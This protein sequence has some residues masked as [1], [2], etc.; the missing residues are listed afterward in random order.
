MRC[1]EVKPL[2][3]TDA[4]LQVYLRDKT[5]EHI[6]RERRPMILIFPGG[7]YAFTADREAE[8]IAL[9]FLALGYQACVLR[10]SV[11]PSDE[12]PALGD[13]PLREAAAALR[14]I[15]ENAEDWG[16]YSDRITVCGFSAGG[17]LA[18]SIG[19]LWHDEHRIPDAGEACKPNG[20]ILSY[21]VCSADVRKTHR[22]SIANL[23]GDPEPC[24]QDVDY[25]LPKLVDEK[26]VPAF[27]WHTAEDDC[28]PV[29]NAFFMARA[30]HKAGRPY[31][32]HIYTHGWHG[33][34]LADAEVGG[35][36]EEVRSWL[37]LAHDWLCSMHLGPDV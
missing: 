23:T 8:P 37:S 29:E 13:R 2:P 9:R 5:Y 20:M 19:T 15:R 24:P 22:G 31:A 35:G 33:L 28:V 36:P 1:F 10:Y 6:R 27:L 34:S 12:Q 14:Y 30:M 3:G 25:D 7:G 21:A 16:V 4:F 18:A 17:H 32:L 26:T 11:R